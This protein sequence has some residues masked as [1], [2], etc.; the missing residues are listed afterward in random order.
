MKQ[1]AVIMTFREQVAKFI[2][3]ENAVA[4]SETSDKYMWVVYNI[5]DMI[6]LPAIES[7]VNWV[8]DQL[9][10]LLVNV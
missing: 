9:E 2:T 5:F 7:R 3:V 8:E 1:R 6:C 4:Y 10:E